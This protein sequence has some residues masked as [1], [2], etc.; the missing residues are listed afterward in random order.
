M[1][2]YTK[3][4][5]NWRCT[6][7]T[8]RCTWASVAYKVYFSG[9]IQWFNWLEGDPF[10]YIDKTFKTVKNNLKAWLSY[11]INICM[12]WNLKSLMRRPTE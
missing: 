8:K 12:Y 4:Y 10:R 11:N 7:E 2:I 1:V 3:F 9:N 6:S 5:L